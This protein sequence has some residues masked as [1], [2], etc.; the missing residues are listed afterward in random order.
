MGTVETFVAYRVGEIQ[1]STNPEQWIYIP[2]NLTPADILSREITAADLAKCDKW[3][4][5]PEFSRK[6]EQSY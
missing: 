1:T 6:P 3:L 4:K 5:G 2:T